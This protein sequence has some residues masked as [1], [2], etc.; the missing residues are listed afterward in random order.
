MRRR[1]AA[2]LLLALLNARPASL[3]SAEHPAAEGSEAGLHG[4]AHPPILLSFGQRPV[5]YTVDEAGSMR[6]VQV[7]MMLQ[8]SVEG[9]NYLV[10]I[11]HDNLRMQVRVTGSRDDVQVRAA[12]PF[13]PGEAYWSGSEIC[14][15]HCEQGPLEGVAKKKPRVHANVFDAH[16]FP[17]EESLLASIRRDLHFEPL[18]EQLPEAMPRTTAAERRPRTRSHASRMIDADLLGDHNASSYIQRWRQGARY[19]EANRRL[20]HGDILPGSLQEYHRERLLIH[21]ARLRQLGEAVLHIPVLWW[22]QQ[23]EGAAFYEA[24]INRHYAL[25]EYSRGEDTVLD[26]FL[27]ELRVPFRPMEPGQRWRFVLEDLHMGGRED[28]SNQ[29]RDANEIIVSH[30]HKLVYVWNRK[31][32]SS[33]ELLSPTSNY[34]IHAVEN[35]NQIGGVPP[36]IQEHLL[37]RLEGSMKWCHTDSMVSRACKAHELDPELY[38]DGSGYIFFSFVQH[39]VRRF[40][41]SLTSSLPR[42]ALLSEHIERFALRLLR[43]LLV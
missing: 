34:P 12:F 24:H 11:Q 17:A 23:R 4:D 25:P 3:Q 42:K 18:I 29:G 31:C 9:F 43:I 20:F 10:V 26:H 28:A 35:C 13:E 7:W 15:V 5:I 2:L 19:Q 37:N 30:K 36:A 38:A 14:T 27:D 6:E 16:L 41:K 33:G 22:W 8:G 39:P 32:A 40:F 21:F 1:T